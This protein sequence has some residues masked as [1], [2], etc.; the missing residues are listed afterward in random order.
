MKNVAKKAVSQPNIPTPKN[1]KAV[2]QLFSGNEGWLCEIP[3]SIADAVSN[4]C[5]L[6]GV[7]PSEIVVKCLEKQL[8]TVAEERH[9][10]REEWRQARNAQFYGKYAATDPA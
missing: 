9:R 8:Q 2:V 1:R 5:E 6:A 3:K 7:S 10:L 4:A